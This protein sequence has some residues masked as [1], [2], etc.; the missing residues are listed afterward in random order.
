MVFTIC[1]GKW[2][3]ATHTDVR[4]GPLG[5]C[6]TV[7]HAAGDVLFWWELEAFSLQRAVDLANVPQIAAT[8]GSCRPR[9]YE[10][11]HLVLNILVGGNSRRGLQ[12]RRQV[13]HKLPRSYLGDEMGASVLHTGVGKVQR[14]ELY[15]WILVPYPALQGAHG[16]LGLDC[17]GANDIRYLEVQR[18][19]L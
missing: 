18:H 6:T 7:K 1:E 5:W 11:Q 2:S 16:I 10:L 4:I 8:L 9:L 3:P 19:V 13:I 17:L 14:S 15:I 12:E